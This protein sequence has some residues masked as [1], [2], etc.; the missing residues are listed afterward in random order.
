MSSNTN[1]TAR[2]A[3]LSVEEVGAELLVY[4]HTAARA[5]CLSET[6]A[7]VWRAC[8]GD[9]GLPVLA[10]VLDLDVETVER[11][12]DELDS[13]GLLEATPAGIAGATRR[14]F[15]L[16][17]V[18]VGAAALSAPLIMSIAAPVAEAT[19]TPTPAMCMGY[20]DKNCNSCTN[21]CGCCCCCQGSAQGDSACKL[22]YPIGLCP[23]YQF[24]AQYPSCGP[25]GQSPGCSATAKAPPNCTPAA[26]HVGCTYVG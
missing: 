14:E 15:S 24:S 4:D 19:V 6:A 20:N 7:R 10:N 16:R 8:D 12:L 1:P 9:T 26:S 25:K 18:K 23:S 11:A 17:S 21:I 2:T 3:D 5:H 13:C 22:C